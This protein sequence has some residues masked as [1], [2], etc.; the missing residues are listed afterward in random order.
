MN[1]ISSH[2][3]GET[4]AASGVFGGTFDKISTCSS[5]EEADAVM[6]TTNCSLCCLQKGHAKSHHITRCPFIKTMGLSINYEKNTDQRRKDYDKN[7]QRASKSKAEQDNDTVLGENLGLVKK[8]DGTGFYSAAETKAYKERQAK[9]KA[10]GEAEAAGTI[11]GA[12]GADAVS[13]K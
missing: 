1:I 9:T 6:K 3:V 8:R 2:Q 10:R 4:R 7:Q 11:V 12:G 5:Q 13:E